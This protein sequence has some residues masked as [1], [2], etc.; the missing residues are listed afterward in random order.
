MV[1]DAVPR[2]NTDYLAAAILGKAPASSVDP[3]VKRVSTQTSPSR[4]RRLFGMRSRE[5]DAT[6]TDAPK[7][8]GGTSATGSDTAPPSGPKKDD[9]VQRAGGDEPST[10]STP[11]SRPRLLNWLRL[12]K[13]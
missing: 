12:R 5:A 4:F 3:A 9:G 10:P 2:S 7:S 13:E 1:V 8:Q 6:A 11:S